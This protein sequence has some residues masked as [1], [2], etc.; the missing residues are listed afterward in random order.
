MT[1]P[2]GVSS[3]AA[4]DTSEITG[5]WR[6]I[7]TRSFSGSAPFTLIVSSITWNGRGPSGV[8]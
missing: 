6:E 4:R 8:R 3:C 2:R 7:R 5:P 1:W